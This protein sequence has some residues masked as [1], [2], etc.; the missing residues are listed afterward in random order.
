[1]AQ[2]NREIGYDRGSM[3]KPFDK[4]PRKSPYCLCVTRDGK[5]QEEEWSSAGSLTLRQDKSAFSLATSFG[6]RPLLCP[7]SRFYEILRR[8]MLGGKPEA[9]GK[10]EEDQ[11][12]QIRDLEHDCT[13]HLTKGE[14]HMGGEWEREENPRKKEKDG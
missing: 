11:Q 7:S 14:R 1:M 6:P 8:R 9:A 10:I 3:R 2:M 12:E 13:A 4:G 5:R